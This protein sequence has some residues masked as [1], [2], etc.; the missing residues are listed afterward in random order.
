MKIYCRNGYMDSSTIFKP[1]GSNQVYLSGVDVGKITGLKW[2]FQKSDLK[3]DFQW[4]IKQLKIIKQDANNQPDDQFLIEEP[5]LIT[6]N[7][8]GHS[9]GFII[10]EKY[11]TM[12]NVDN[13]IPST[14]KFSHQSKAA[15][16][17]TSH[18][19]SSSTSTISSMR[20]ISRVTDKPR[21]PSIS[22][23]SSFSSVIA[24]G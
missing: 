16:R 9:N 8:T 13:K 21:E 4:N 14:M 6:Y 1:N 19:S 23:Q 15:K 3:D 20:T 22:S 17:S 10:G 5:T 24:K 18:T 2:Y 7:D 12:R 11:A